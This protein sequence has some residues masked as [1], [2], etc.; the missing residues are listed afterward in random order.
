M[1]GGDRY[2]GRGAG[3]D[4]GEKVEDGNDDWNGGR[5]VGAD[6]GA[7]IGAGGGVANAGELLPD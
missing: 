1:Y 5:G 3:A 6:A 2:G 4:A 7:N